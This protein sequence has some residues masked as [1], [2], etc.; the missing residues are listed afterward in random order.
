MVRWFAV[1]CAVFLSQLLLMISQYAN[2]I[3]V[4]NYAG[5][6]LRGPVLCEA[7]VF[8]FSTTYNSCV[9]IS[10]PDTFYVTVIH[11]HSSI[12]AKNTNRILTCSNI[13]MQF[14]PSGIS[15]NFPNIQSTLWWFS[16]Q[17]FYKKMLT[18]IFSL[19]WEVGWKVLFHKE[20]E[21]WNLFS[22]ANFPVG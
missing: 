7:H 15:L 18:Q 10:I 9:D 22:F 17:G 12:L 6:T 21:T 13:S 3:G 20:P 16:F 5:F 19:Y 8:V 1:G 4:M 14:L 2:H 11:R